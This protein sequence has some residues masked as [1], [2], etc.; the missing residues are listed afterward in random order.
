MWNMNIFDLYQALIQLR[1]DS[2][3]I[4]QGDYNVLYSK[5]MFLY[6]RE[7]IS[8]KRLLLHWIQNS[9]VNVNYE[10]DGKYVDY[11]SK[12]KVNVIESI[13]ANG[14]YILFSE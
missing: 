14:F 4:R 8:Q 5:G 6:M 1:K 7:A 12:E 11:F 3:A 10:L 9:S 13:P 2:L